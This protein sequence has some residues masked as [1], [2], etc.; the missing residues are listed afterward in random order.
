MKKFLSILILLLLFFTACTKKEEK[1]QIDKIIERDILIVGINPNVKPFGFKN[2]LTDEIEGFDADIAKYIA[3][4]ILGSERKIQ[5]IPVTPSTRIEAITSGAVD[6]VIATMSITPQRQFLID[7]TNP[8][9]IA[10]QTAIVKEDSNIHNFADLKNKTTIVVLGTT[11]EQN[12]RRI[13]PTAKLNGYKN[14]Q[15]A[16]EAFKEG[17]ADAISTDNTI[18]S[19]FLIDNKGYRMLKNKISQEPY[20]IGIKR[21]EK[22]ESLK[23]N[24]NIIINRLQKDGT[25]K[26]LKEK[27]QIK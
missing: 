5:F 2:K 4:D 25:I 21:N 19:G 17:Q 9:Y 13:I 20:A 3:K 16:F 26:T 24:L 23:K 27:W 7:F 12:I 18:L 11:S 22:D 8:Y 14:Y 10:G 1:T 6:M 15:E